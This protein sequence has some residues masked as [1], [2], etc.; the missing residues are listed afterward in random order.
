[1][2]KKVMEIAEEAGQIILEGFYKNKE[3]RYKG[4]SD[5]VTQYDVMVED[6]VV[7]KI[8]KLYPS[9][10]IMGEESTTDT[11]NQAPNIIYIDPIDG[12]T[13]FVHSYPFV[14]VS[15]G[16]YTDSLGDIGVVYN[17]IL[18]EM[19][20]AQ[21]GSGAFC[22]GTIISVSKEEDL[23]HSL[24]ATGFPYDKSTLP[25]VVKKFEKLLNK[26]QD[27]RRSGSSALDTCYVA[28]GSLDL[29]YEGAVKPWDI[30]AG[31]IIAT[32][33]GGLISDINGSDQHLKTNS[34]IVANGTLHKKFLEYIN[35]G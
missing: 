18:K 19:F 12:T 11:S 32:E 24:F 29:Y 23:S 14:A 25:G 16:V 9:Y 22:N 7:D 13:N 30:S 20:Y 6:F 26:S 34:I 3:V 15:I 4:A 5:L 35:E 21:K 10:Q 17:P 28:K 33:A 8:R 27:A 1:M 2:L 31:A